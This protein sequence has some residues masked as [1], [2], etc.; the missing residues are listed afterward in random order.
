[1]RL[2]LTA[3]QLAQKQ[4]PPKQLAKPFNTSIFEEPLEEFLRELKTTT[5]V[6]VKTPVKDL[7]KRS[8]SMQKSW[9]KPVVDFFTCL[10]AKFNEMTM[11]KGNAA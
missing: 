10:I 11:K 4:L 1:M 9:Y 2:R 8:H 6:E 3:E 5:E 7:S